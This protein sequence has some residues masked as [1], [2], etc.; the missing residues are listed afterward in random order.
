MQAKILRHDASKEYF[1]QEGC[2]INELS[3]HEEDGDLSIAR[4]RVEPGVTTRLHRLNHSVERYCILSGMGRVEVEGLPIQ[5]VSA[6]DV[7]LIPSGCYQRICNTGDE[8]LIFL[9]LCTP[10]FQRGDYIE[11]D[12]TEIA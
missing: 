3:N 5:I 7:V 6:G 2:Y 4:A 9:A 1:F 8:D 12:E 10:R 11:L